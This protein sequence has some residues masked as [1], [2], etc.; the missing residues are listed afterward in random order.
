[1]TTHRLRKQYTRA[2]DYEGRETFSRN[3]AGWGVLV[4]C[5]LNWDT[6]WRPCSFLSSWVQS[7]HYCTRH[8]RCC[9][10]ICNSAADIQSWYRSAYRWEW[11]T[12]TGSFVLLWIPRRVGGLE[13]GRIRQRHTW[14]FLRW[15]RICVDA[16]PSSDRMRGWRP[17]RRSF[18]CE[19]LVAW[20][21]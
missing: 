5:T 15:W 19:A 13:W 2:V 6:I 9:T 3:T 17:R 14:F 7:R 4:R 8:V 12:L 21:F 11:W 20:R 1:M 10:W 16:G 18:S